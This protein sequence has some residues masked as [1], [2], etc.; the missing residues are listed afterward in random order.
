MSAR[1]HLPPAQPRQASLPGQRPPADT[2]IHHERQRRR[3]WIRPGPRTGTP[4]AETTSTNLHLASPSSSTPSTRRR[5]PKTSRRRI[6]AGS[7][8]H[9]PTA[10][11]RPRRGGISP[12]RTERGGGRRRS[13]RGAAPAA[14]RKRLHYSR[15]SRHRES[16]PRATTPWRLWRI[17]PAAT[18]DLAGGSGGR[19]AVE[20]LPRGGA[21]VSPRCRPGGRHGSVTCGRYPVSCLSPRSKDPIT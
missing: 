9:G 7:Q 19:R 4:P 10:C 17:G 6:W 11:T 21:R 18:A 15:P 20:G 13:T 2:T 3:R 14:A 8:I 16:P 5:W 12:A 1:P